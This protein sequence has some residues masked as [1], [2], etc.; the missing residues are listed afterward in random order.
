MV[1]TKHR[2]QLSRILLVREEKPF[3]DWDKYLTNQEVTII[4]H[5]RASTK[6]RGPWNLRHTYLLLLNIN[7]LIKNKIFS[8]PKRET[9]ESY[10][11]KQNLHAVR[12]KSIWKLRFFRVVMAIISNTK[13]KP[14][15]PINQGSCKSNGFSLV[16]FLRNQTKRD[17]DKEYLPV[18]SVEKTNQVI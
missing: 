12:N 9:E 10:R 14:I 18:D 6:V 4:H 17:L 8:D 3:M 7:S 11:E 5:W 16:C 1:I 13:W 2:N 15:K